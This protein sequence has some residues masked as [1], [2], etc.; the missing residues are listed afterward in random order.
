MKAQ[1]EKLAKEVGIPTHKSARDGEGHEYKYKDEILEKFAELIVKE[2]GNYL[3]S[4]EF[5][6]RGDLNWDMVLNEHF[7]IK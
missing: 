6:G 7:N 3:Q 1:F 2:C 4:K 5:I